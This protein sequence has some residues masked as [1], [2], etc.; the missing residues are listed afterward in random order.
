M[1]MLVNPGVVVVSVAMAAAF[2]LMESATVMRLL[3][4]ARSPPSSSPSRPSLP[5]RRPTRPSEGDRCH[6]ASS[7]PHS[8][9][10]GSEPSDNP[11]G[12]DGAPASGIIYQPNDGTIIVDIDAP[13]VKIHQDQRQKP[14]RFRT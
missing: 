8:P 12:D 9:C 4:A 1:D 10:R 6:G 7:D 2:V 14:F 3:M 11:P 5:S 13:R